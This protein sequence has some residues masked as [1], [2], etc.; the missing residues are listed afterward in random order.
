MSTSTFAAWPR[1]ER[2]LDLHLREVLTDLA[3]GCSD[4]AL[5]D[6]EQL[7]ERPLPDPLRA[8]YRGHDGQAGDAPAGLFYGMTFLSL[9]GAA[10]HW[11]EWQ[12]LRDRCCAEETAGLNEYAT[13]VPADT[14]ATVYSD[15][16][17]IPVAHD[18]GGNYLGVDLAPGPAGTVGQVIN[19]GRDEDRKFVL[20]PS[21]DA[22]V[23]RL[24][25]ELE[26][27]N[28][29]IQVEDDGGRSFNVKT[30]RSGHFLDAAKKLFGG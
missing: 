17:W 21:F 15:P 8:F 13:S 3:P 16:G 27:G 23:E 18:Y 28:F 6:F 10:E 30:P 25:A 29:H 24:L 14:I 19:F 9:Q 11:K 4:D 7:V 20:A 5:R 2:W 1:L 26:S 12:A 22:F